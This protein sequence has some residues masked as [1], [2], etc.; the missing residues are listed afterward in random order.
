M[1][2]SK[3]QSKYYDDSISHDDYI[4]RNPNR[5]GAPKNMEANK[6]KNSNPSSLDGI[7]A[8]KIKEED[9]MTSGDPSALVEQ[10]KK[11]SK[12]N[13]KTLKKSARRRSPDLSSVNQES[14]MKPRMKHTPEKKSARK[15]SGRKKSGGKKPSLN[16]SP[17]EAKE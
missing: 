5:K 17:E 8:I 16:H 15:K 9:Q 3:S 7:G 6:G 12:K 2:K 11:S 4:Y 10:F 14:P 13:Q 1:D